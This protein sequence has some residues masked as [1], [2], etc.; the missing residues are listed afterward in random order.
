MEN[1]DDE[2][3]MLLTEKKDGTLGRPTK[4]DND[5]VI[6]AICRID[7]SASAAHEKMK[8]GHYSNSENS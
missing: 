5:A 7:I 4:E 6:D 2:A 1:L 3:Q 8:I